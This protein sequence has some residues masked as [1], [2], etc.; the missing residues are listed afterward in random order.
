MSLAIQLAKNAQNMEMKL[1]INV[2]SVN[3]DM[4]LKMIQ[5][6]VKF[7]I[8]N[9]TIIFIMMIMKIFNAL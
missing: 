6:M 2:S 1:I 8:K 3:Q 9:V 7:V 5:K 4:N